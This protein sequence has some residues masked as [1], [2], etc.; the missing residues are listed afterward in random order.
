MGFKMKSRR[1]A[2][3]GS[4]PTTHCEPFAERFRSNFKVKEKKRCGG[5]GKEIG[6]KKKK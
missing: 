5:E 1:K 3:E 2:A 4:R 6:K